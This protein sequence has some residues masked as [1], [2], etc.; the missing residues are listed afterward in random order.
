MSSTVRFGTA[1]NALDPACLSTANHSLVD[2]AVL[3]CC[4][5][6]HEGTHGEN[7]VCF[8]HINQQ[9]I[10]AHFMKFLKIQSLL[11]SMS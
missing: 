11:K 1:Q 10:H 7:K 3:P 8:T 6:H 9:E 4:A 5:T 2:G